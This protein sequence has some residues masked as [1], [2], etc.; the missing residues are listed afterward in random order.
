MKAKTF[1]LQYERQRAKARRKKNSPCQAYV[2]FSQK[3]GAHGRNETFLNRGI[4]KK[5]LLRRSVFNNLIGRSRSKRV[6]VYSLCRPT[7]SHCRKVDL[8][9]NRGCYIHKFLLCVGSLCPFFLSFSISTCLQ[10]QLIY[11]CVSL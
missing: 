6:V 1:L 9:G 7:N 3:N 4:V 8:I 5:P 2:L 11:V 10:L